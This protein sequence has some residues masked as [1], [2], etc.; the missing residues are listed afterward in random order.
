MDSFEINKVIGAVLFCVL[1]IA[2]INI[3]GDALVHPRQLAEPA[4]K[5]AGVEEEAK[6]APGIPAKAPEP[7]EPLPVLLAKASAE[8]GEKAAKKCAACHTFE[9]GGPSRVGP[10]LYGVVGGKT[11]H[12]AGFAYSS[13]L[14]GKG[15]TWGFAEL[16][17]FLTSPKDYISGTKMAFAGVKSAKERADILAYLRTLADS[18]VPL[19]SQ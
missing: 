4:Y 11:A 5:V 10:N 8:A 17:A 1:L 3:V 18:P 14:Q 2:A 16:D 15:G 7:A 19:P 9:K 6:P 13:G 12:A